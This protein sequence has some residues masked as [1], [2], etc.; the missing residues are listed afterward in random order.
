MVIIYFSDKKHRW[1]FILI[2]DSVPMKLTFLGSENKRSAN[3]YH[4]PEMPP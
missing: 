1:I 4:G 3:D 2:L